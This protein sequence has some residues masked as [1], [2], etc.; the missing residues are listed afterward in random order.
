MRSCGLTLKFYSNHQQRTDIVLV[1]TTDNKVTL[2]TA[3]C[4]FFRD[5]YL[6]IRLQARVFYEQIVN[7]AQ[8]SWLSLAEN[9]GE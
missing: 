2:L 1:F 3:T 9:E 7:E 8:P 6:R 4:Q 5:F